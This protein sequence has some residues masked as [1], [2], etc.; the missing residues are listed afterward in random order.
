MKLNIL[1]KKIA[2]F[3]SARPAL[4]KLGFFIIYLFHFEIIL[5][6]LQIIDLATQLFS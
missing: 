2:C 4:I 5:C 6:K 1:K 3:I